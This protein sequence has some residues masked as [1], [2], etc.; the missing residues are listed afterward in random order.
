MT[1]RLDA[2]TTR[3]LDALTRRWGV[4]RSHAIARAI[5]EACQRPA[6]S[7]VSTTEAGT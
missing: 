2:E 6:R 3:A 4:V 1:L 7:S 5:A